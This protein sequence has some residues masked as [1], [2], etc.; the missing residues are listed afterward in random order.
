M[1]TTKKE[2]REDEL[3]AAFAHIQN[4]NDWEAS[5]EAAAA[6]ARNDT[7]SHDDK[8]NDNSHTNNHYWQ[9]AM[10]FAAAQRILERLGGGNKNQPKLNEP[11]DYRNSQGETEEDEI[12]PNTSETNDTIEDEDTKIMTLYQQQA[13]EYFFRARKALLQAMK[14]ENQVDEMLRQQQQRQQQQ[15]QQQPPQQQEQGAAPTT[16]ETMGSGCGAD[17]LPDEI[18]HDRLELFSR[19]FARDCHKD[20][21][22]SAAAAAASSHPP[23]I[24]EMQSS[25]EQ[26]LLQL[27]DSLPVG[28]KTSEQRMREINRGLN[29]L[30][31]SL[32]SASEGNGL[33][34]TALPKSEEEQVNEIIAQARDEVALNQDTITNNSNPFT[35]LEP[36][37]TVANDGQVHQNDTADSDLDSID[38]EKSDNSTVD[39]EPD[40]TLDQ[41][42]CIREKAVEAQVH[43]AQLIALLEIDQSGDAEIQFCPSTGKHTLNEARKLLQSAAIEWTSN[44][45][46][47]DQK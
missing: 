28:F 16:T 29:R 43:L 22:Q 44:R 23:D 19:L 42:R 35:P 20:M 47:K 6:A 3:E 26:R 1:A 13:D 33:A 27:N 9:A 38:D 30:G 7:S 15:P 14:V 36:T 41:I 5:A 45:K 4:G 34:R 10:E 46:E 40:L 21:I 11:S 32:Y 17:R 37:A 12:V 39:D 24:Q 2:E 31:F 25:I 18:A 8:N